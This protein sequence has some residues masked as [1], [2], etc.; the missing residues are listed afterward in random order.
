[1]T[2]IKG[3]ADL[4]LLPFVDV[5]SL[6]DLKRAALLFDKI[7]PVF[8]TS[9]PRARRARFPLSAAFF[10]D[11][12]ERGRVSAELDWLYDRQ[13]L[14]V[15]KEDP[16]PTGFEF[17]DYEQGKPMWILRLSDD[18]MRA[19]QF[20]DSQVGIVEA[21][22][23]P[24]FTSAGPVFLTEKRL[25]PEPAPTPASGRSAIVEVVL[26]MFP[27]PSD[28][29][30][31]EAILDWRADE[32]ARVKRQRLVRWMNSVGERQNLNVP[33]LVDEIRSLLD[34]YVAAMKVHDFKARSGVF[35]TVV[36]TTAELA[37][38]ILK[39]KLADLA[40]LPFKISQRHVERLGA[41]LQAPGKELAY[42]VETK[43]RFYK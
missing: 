17:E 8:R 14:D 33:S 18:S 13:L 38:N 5:T 1:M 20:G 39:L 28:D 42:I 3:H 35:R 40:D 25:R 10:P 31:W 27:E 37:E 22:N 43:A 21:L 29:T 9:I 6:S 11:E 41:E 16:F 36:T 19:T 7:A 32:E 12:E 30:P 26:S 34:D 4:V 15:P 2:R 23:E 24:I